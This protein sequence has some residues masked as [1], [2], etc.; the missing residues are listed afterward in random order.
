MLKTCLYDNGRLS[1]IAMLRA[2]AADV[3]IAEAIRSKVASRAKDGF[4]AE[5][6]NPAP[7]SSMA[8]IGG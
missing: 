2:G 7:K 5:A 8:A 1:L 6:L 4:A 3:E